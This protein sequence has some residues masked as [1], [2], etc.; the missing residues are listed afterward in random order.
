MNI[1]NEILAALIPIVG[2]VIGA[3]VW[4]WQQRAKTG[5]IMAENER[6]KTEADKND[7]SERNALISQ[8]LQLVANNT[9]ALESLGD[10]LTH[11]RESETTRNEMLTNTLREMIDQLKALRIDVKAYPE[12]ATG[13][14]NIVSD[15]IRALSANVRTLTQK[16]EGVDTLPASYLA[17]KTDIAALSRKCTTLIERL[18]SD[19]KI[20]DEKKSAA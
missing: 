8:S 5:V 4:V 18:D 15:D 19:K 12:Q 20:E 14:L 1:S 10:E 9:K 2:T 3:V 6:L 11:N 16:L 17:I 13:A 7:D